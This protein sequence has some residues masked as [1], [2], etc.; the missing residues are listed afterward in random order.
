MDLKVQDSPPIP[1]SGDA[2]IVN[3][4]LFIDEQDSEPCRHVRTQLS[5]EEKTL[6]RKLDF[7]I[8]VRTYL[9]VP[10]NKK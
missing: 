1:K 4:K 8:M 5:P 10:S 3:A 7:Y 6:V 2:A 9:R